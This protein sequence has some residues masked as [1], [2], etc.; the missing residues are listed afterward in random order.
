VNGRQVNAIVTIQLLNK[1][2]DG[3]TPTVEWSGKTEPISVALGQQAQP[4]EITLGRGDLDNLTVTAVEI[5]DPPP[6]LTEGVT[7]TLTA[8]V[9][10]PTGAHA[11]WG[12]LDES[13]ATVDAAGVVTALRD[14]TAR[15]V[16]SAGLVADTVSLTVL[17]RPASIALSQA[18]LTFAAIGA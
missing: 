7:A 8:T 16:A 1:P 11:F 13:V 2:A 14:G 3:G 18:S 9:A 12:S 15:I 5:V 10:G 17:Q 6:T 4:A